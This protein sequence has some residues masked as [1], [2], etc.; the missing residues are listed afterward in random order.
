MAL[1]VINAQEI[2]FV[3]ANRIQAPFLHPQTMAEEMNQMQKNGLWG[4]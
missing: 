3:K 1:N 2:V 4:V